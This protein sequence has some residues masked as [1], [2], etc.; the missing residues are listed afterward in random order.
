MEIN[1]HKANTIKSCSVVDLI[2]CS[3]NDLVSHIQSQFLPGMTW[4]NRFLWYIDHIRPCASFDIIDPEQ[5]RQCFHYTNLQPLWAK[6]NFSKGRK[7]T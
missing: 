4:E 1:S 6:D 2:G 7:W 3:P 5:Q